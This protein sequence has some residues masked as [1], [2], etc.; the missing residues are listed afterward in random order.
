MNDRTP[1]TPQPS[2]ILQ[3]AAARVAKEARAKGLP[4]SAP[5]RD[6]HLDDQARLLPSFGRLAQCLRR[7]KF[8]ALY[9]SEGPDRWALA[10]AYGSAQEGSIRPFLDFWRQFSDPQWRFATIA[11]IG[12]F[13]SGAGELTFPDGLTIRTRDR[14]ALTGMG[15]TE[16]DL[17]RTVAADWMESSGGHGLFVMVL[18]DSVPKIPEHIALVNTG[19]EAERMFRLLQALRLHGPGEVGLG[20]TFSHRIEPFSVGIGGYSGTAS[21]PGPGFGRALVLEEEDRHFVAQRYRQL[22]EFD[23]S[24][25]SN[26]GHVAIALSRFGSAYDRPWFSASDRLIDDAIALEALVGAP[27]PELTYT[28]A[29]RVSALLSENDAERVALF[30]RIRS[31]YGTRSRLVHGDA[32]KPRHLADIQREPELR[33]VVRRLLRGFLNLA[34]SET[35]Y[36]SRRFV[37]TLDVKLLDGSTRDRIREAMDAGPA[38]AAMPAS[39]ITRTTPLWADQPPS[40]AIV[41]T[42]PPD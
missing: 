14:R 42:G 5:L 31:F 37:D 6:T 20:R 39:N 19:R 8:N 35:L 3:E 32:L 16:E 10:W 26:L 24:H 25:A 30:E 29:T 9:G 33:D 15:W 4:P 40:S 21:R 7:S 18:E 13:E 11:N 17:E 36:P 28:L 38:A 22:A 23:V 27:G 34:E 2:R 41:T 12:N 1:P